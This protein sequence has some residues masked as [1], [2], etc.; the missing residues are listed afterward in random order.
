MALMIFQN[1]ERRDGQKT[2]TTCEEP[3][4]RREQ[5]IA[6]SIIRLTSA[7]VGR[8][9][10]LLIWTSRTITGD[11]A[12]KE[13]FHTVEGNKNSPPPLNDYVSGSF[14]I[15]TAETGEESPQCVTATNAPVDK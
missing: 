12:G 5:D 4:R 11:S 8:S 3:E 14:F 13:T 9:A 15:K 10:P 7:P 2:E 6:S 1:V